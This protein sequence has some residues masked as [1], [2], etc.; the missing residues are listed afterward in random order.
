[1]NS[2]ELPSR[3]GSCVA[4]TVTAKLQIPS[5]LQRPATSTDCKYVVF[6]RKLQVLSDKLL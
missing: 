1:M 4:D 3:I 2:Q 6:V 5:D